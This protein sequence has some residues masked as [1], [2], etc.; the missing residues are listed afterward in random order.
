MTKRFR[1]IAGPNGSG[2]STLKRH[3]ERDYAVNFYD[4]LNADDIFAEVKKTGAY[5]PNFAIDGSLEAFA[6]H[7]HYDLETVKFFTSHEI[8]VESD[9]VRFLNPAA[10][11]SYTIALLTA[12][13]QEES[14]RQ[15]RSCSQETVFS[16]PS[17]VEA[18]RYARTCGYR[19]YLYFVATDSPQINLSRVANR[20]SSGGHTVPDEKV[21]SRYERSLLNL[22][23]ALH[24]LSRAYFFD[25][26]G[27]EMRYL[28]EWNEEAGFKPTMASSE[29]PKWFQRFAMA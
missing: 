6:S 4:Y 16:H 15:G 22:P 3:L 12:F 29:L 20:A 26:S 7:S 21:I 2:K 11:N 24:F 19:T 9:C 14:I 18:L 1:M 8:M 5:L 13:L 27:D 28:A 10:I 17:K 23:E 25:N